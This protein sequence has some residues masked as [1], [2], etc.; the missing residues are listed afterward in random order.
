MPGRCLRRL[1]AALPL[2]VLTAAA[3]CGPT[4]VDL[5]QT[6]RV[7]DVSSGFTPG[8]KDGQARIVPTVTFRLEKQAAATELDRVSLDLTFNQPGGEQID[9][10]FLKSLDVGPTGSEPLTVRADTGYT[11]P[12]PQAPADL[13]AN[14]NFQDVTVRI[15]ARQVSGSWVEL[16]TGAIERRLLDR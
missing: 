6:L 12:Q 3:G 13:L 7:V 2:L 8:E 9:N 16:Y 14:S 15:L 5:R 10:I 1:A 11:G 4:L